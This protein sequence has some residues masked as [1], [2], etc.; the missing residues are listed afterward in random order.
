ML[1]PRVSEVLGVMHMKAYVFDDTGALDWQPV[2]CLMD[3]CGMQ[4]SRCSASGVVRWATRSRLCMQLEGCAWQR[5]VPR[6]T[7]GP[8]LAP[9]PPRPGAAA[10]ILSGANISSTYLSSRQDRYMVL[11]NSPQLAAFL[12]SV[13][14]AVGRF[15]Y[16]LLPADAAAA[17][18]AAT[19]GGTRRG[20]A[21]LQL[22]AR[23]QQLL[24][25]GAGGAA[26]AGAATPRRHHLQRHRSQ[27]SQRYSLAPCPAGVDPVLQAPLFC[28]ALRQHLLQ[29]FAPPAAWHAILDFAALEAEAMEGTLA[30]AAA[31]DAAAGAQGASQQQLAEELRQQSLGQAGGS[32]S[33]LRHACGRHSCGASWRHG[34]GPARHLDRAAGAGGVCWRAAGRTLHAEGAVVGHAAAAADAAAEWRQQRQ[35]RGGR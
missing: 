17:A 30:A 11:R 26:A 3:P 8:A 32:G 24:L 29:L 15:S 22:L 31:A 35:R 10:V 12:E 6:A 13:V 19:E 9:P 23:Q 1:P 33:P 4:R 25:G 28:S 34:W 16:Q 14:A 27:R 18:P 7:A 20:D 5:S 2:L 21:L